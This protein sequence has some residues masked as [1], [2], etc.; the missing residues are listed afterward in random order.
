MINFGDLPDQIAE[1]GGVGVILNK[2]DVDYMRMNTHNLRSA[3]VSP[4]CVANQ[5][6]MASIEKPH[7]GDLA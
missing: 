6:L 7:K 3:S 5:D 1:L 2:I 4:T